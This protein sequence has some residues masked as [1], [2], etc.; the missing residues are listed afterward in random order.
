M[1]TT[2]QP[3][4]TSFGCWNPAPYSCH[5][6]S[7]NIYF[8]RLE[9]SPSCPQTGWF[10]LI[11]RVSSFESLF[12]TGCGEKSNGIRKHSGKGSQRN[13]LSPRST[14]SLWCRSSASREPPGK[15]APTRSRLL[16]SQQ[17]QDTNAPLIQKE[18]LLTK[19]QRRWLRLYPLAEEINLDD[20]S[21][22]G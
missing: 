13:I 15:A 2:V 16:S 1:S 10:F 4:Q 14:Y 8:F 19:G 22:R 21:F 11:L 17:S 18:P 12:E 6:L 3:K 7:E 9:H 5:V 20:A